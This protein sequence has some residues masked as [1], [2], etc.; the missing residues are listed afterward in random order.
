MQQ[1]SGAVK[2]WLLSPKAG[3]T[4]ASRNGE[5]L[6]SIWLNSSFESFQF[7][8]GPTTLTPYIPS[9]MAPKKTSKKLI[10]I[11]QPLRLQSTCTARLNPNPPLRRPKL[12]L[13]PLQLRL[14]IPDALQQCSRRCKLENLP[15]G[16]GGRCQKSVMTGMSLPRCREYGSFKCCCNAAFFRCC[17]MADGFLK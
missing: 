9:E 14:K 8:R 13:C 6:P 12:K 5:I 3:T 16:G 11:S 10:A 7:L 1:K 17:G 2:N 15:P 4:N